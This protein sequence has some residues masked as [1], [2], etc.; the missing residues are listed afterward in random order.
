[1]KTPILILCLLCCGF[2]ALAQNYITQT[3]ILYRNGDD[4]VSERCCL[5]VT[6]QKGVSGKPVIV[7]FHGGGLTKGERYTPKAFLTKDYVIVAASYRLAPQT[8]VIEILKDAAYAVRWTQKNIEQYGGDPD[9]IYL[10]GHSAGGYIVAMLG[11]D[12]T[13]LAKHGVDADKLAAVVPFSGQ[14]IT[15][16]TERASRGIPNTRPVID[17]MAPLYHIRADAAPFLLI[18]G[19]RDKE[20]MR[21]YEENLYFYE[22]MRLIGHKD[23]ELHEAK[24]C[25]HSGMREPGYEILMN[26]I[27]SRTL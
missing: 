3:G 4:Y 27:A 20:M 1:M 24:G 18:T 12:K 9:K 26:Y 16:Y 6:Y 11:L 25:T 15:H 23:I 22:M 5:D 21:R 2:T 10:A 14:L 8:P 19:D 17:N 7:W 13:Y